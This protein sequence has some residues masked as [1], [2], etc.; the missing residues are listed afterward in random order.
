M[1]TLYLV[2]APLSAIQAYCQ[3]LHVG[4]NGEEGCKEEAKPIPT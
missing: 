1:H 2:S 4:C 3:C